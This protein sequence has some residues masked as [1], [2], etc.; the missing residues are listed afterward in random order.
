MSRADTISSSLQMKT[1]SPI[2]VAATAVA[3]A[4]AAPA[5]AQTTPRLTFDLRVDGS[6]AKDANVSKP[7]EAITLDLFASVYGTD[8]DPTNERFRSVMGGF[9]SASGG[10]AGD[11]IGLNPPTPFNGSASGSGVQRDLDS[12][13]DLDIGSNDP[14]DNGS[15][16]L[17]Y[18]W[19]YARSNTEVPMTNPPGEF[20]V[21]QVR[22]TATSLSSPS[23]TVSFVPRAYSYLGAKY[24]AIAV[25]DNV[26]A[27]MRGDDSRISIAAPVTI[28]ATT[29]IDP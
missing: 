19:Y 14:A 18:P 29:V 26:L 13:G 17:L 10:L 7:G 21:G 4:L 23:T 24:G 5:L 1:F 25:F 27:S 16:A 22:F 20:L 3:I 2:R 8:A 11:L 15:G 6:G 9:R 12:D 28:H